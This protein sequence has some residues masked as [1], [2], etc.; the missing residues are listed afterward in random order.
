MKINLPLNELQAEHLKDILDNHL[1]QLNDITIDDIA[2]D[3]MAD[4]VEDALLMNETL[5]SSRKEAHELRELLVEA[6]REHRT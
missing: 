4:T 6:L 2:L 1:E 3:M 5:D